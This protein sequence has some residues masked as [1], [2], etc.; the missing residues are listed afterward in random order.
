MGV[1]GIAAGPDQIA[2]GDDPSLLAAVDADGNLRA[3]QF[4]QDAAGGQREQRLDGGGRVTLGSAEVFVALLIEMRIQTQYLA[5]IASGQTLT[6]DP[7]TLRQDADVA[8]LL[9]TL[10]S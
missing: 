9:A 8:G 10:S 2:D 3:K 7:E 4:G 6:D 5:A 1:L